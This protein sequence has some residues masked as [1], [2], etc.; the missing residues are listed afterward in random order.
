MSDTLF[1]IPRGWVA[2]E[3]RRLAQR[4]DAARWTPP[5]GLDD[6][7]L[8]YTGTETGQCS[9]VRF[10][11][12]VSD[13]QVWCS[14][15]VSRGRGPYGTEWAYFWTRASRFLT[16]FPPPLDLTGYVDSSEWDERIAAAGV[17]KI[18]LADLPDLLAPYGVEVVGAPARRA[19]A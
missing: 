3:S 14:S 4:A 10:A 18:D 15:D 6:I 2:A 12:S 17:H 7:A 19:A 8:L 16:I 5:A 1:D 11:A 13:A 9:G